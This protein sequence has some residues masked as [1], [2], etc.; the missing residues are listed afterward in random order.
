MTEQQVAEIKDESKPEYEINL[1]T[2]EANVTLV[3]VHQ[4]GNYLVGTTD[5]GVRF[6]QRIPQGKILNKL[7]G[8]W[9]LEDI[10]VREPEHVS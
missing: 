7:D 3:D 1:D 8:K 2:I 9:I 4:E 10:E 5:K 6:R